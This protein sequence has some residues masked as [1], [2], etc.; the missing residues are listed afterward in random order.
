[1]LLWMVIA[2]LAHADVSAEPWPQSVRDFPPD[3][4]S[5]LTAGDFR[6]T[7]SEPRDP[8]MRT[9]GGSGGPMLAFTVRDQKSRW[10]TTFYD[11]SVGTRLLSPFASH[12]QLEIWARGG[13]GSWSRCLIR[14]VRGEYRCVRID[15]FSSSRDRA[16]KPSITTT[17]PLSGDTLY[18]VETRI[19]DESGGQLPN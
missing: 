5:T 1:M 12:P 9:L 10:T 2:A 18:F 3:L 15:K 13:G 14:F 4:P 6:I 16:T 8:Q 19:P 17:L 11:Q 7:V